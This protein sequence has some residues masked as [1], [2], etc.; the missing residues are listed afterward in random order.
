MFR[1][2]LAVSALALLSACGDGQPFFNVEN[3]NGGDGEP[4][5][6]TDPNVRVDNRFAFD[7]TRSLTMNSVEYD[8]ANDE[9][10]INNLP[11]DGPTQRYDRVGRVPTGVPGQRYYESRQTSTTGLIQHYA[12][13]L[14]SDAL[15]ATAANGAE[16][17][18]FGYG[19]ANINRDS[20]NLPDS[21]EYVY[22]GVYSGVR[23]L[24]ER[25]GL[26]LVAGDI[27]IL[28]DIDDLDPSGDIQGSII[29]TVTGRTTTPV[30]GSGDQYALPDVVM[31][32]VS[33]NT[34]EGFFEEGAASTFD[35][36]GDVRDSGTYEGLIAGENGEEIGG[37]VIL[38][39]N[40][41]PQTIEFEVIEW[42]RTVGGTT[43]R[44]TTSALESVETEDIQAIVDR[45]VTVD[46]LIAD[47]TLVPDDAT[48]L[49][50][51]IDTVDFET[52]YEA[53]ELG[54]FITDQ[55]IP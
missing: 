19:G 49:G 16:W 47:R 50:T 4:I 18:D 33:F 45:R 35:R 6:P 17:R 3:P 44:G 51:I 13:F 5:D 7:L 14:R 23:T 29:G 21:G 1:L 28:L 43:I 40:A 36:N 25:S 55:V 32:R 46:R 26:E 42:E 11:F 34:E 22:V 9:L 10:I 8:R 2:T 37:Y 27:E 15:E 20:F 54:I 38:E 41:R 24:S 39:G 52:S 12:V 53:R 31:S 30:L 48:I